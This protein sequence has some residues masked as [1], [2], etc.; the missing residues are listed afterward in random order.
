MKKIFILLVI[1]LPLAGLTREVKKS[2]I[3]LTGSDTTGL[4]HDSRD[5]EGAA[6]RGDSAFIMKDNV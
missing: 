2:G 1:I 4:F 6:G 3:L 5:S